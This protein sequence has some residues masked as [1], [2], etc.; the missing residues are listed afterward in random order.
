LKVV[1][2]DENLLRNHSDE[3]SLWREES[4]KALRVKL[5]YGHPCDCWFSL[6]NKDSTLDAYK[7]FS[8]VDKDS[9]ERIHPDDAD[10]LEDQTVQCVSDVKEPFAASL[11]FKI[12]TDP[13]VGRLAFPCLFRTFRC[14]FC[15]LNTRS[16]NKERISRI[17]QM[18]AN[19]QN[20]IDFIEAGDIGAQ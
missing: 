3:N 19:K 20:P 8:K 17:Y 13:F 1:D 15:V 6:K 12:A 7:I 14:R 16:G 2:Y 18:H 11:V 10:L 4:T 5:W 9:I